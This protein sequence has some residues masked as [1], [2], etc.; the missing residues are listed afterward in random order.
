ML[1]L[2]DPPDGWAELLQTR[3]NRVGGF[4]EETDLLPRDLQYRR[5]FDSTQ[6]TGYYSNYVTPGL[7]GLFILYPFGLE[8]R[9]LRIVEL[10]ESWQV[11]V[12]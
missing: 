10:P 3:W 9:V 1:P 12:D 6:G 8:R 2:P 7:R 11:P 4:Y 5:T